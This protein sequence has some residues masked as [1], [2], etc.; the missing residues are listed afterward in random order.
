LAHA[1]VPFNNAINPA[2]I[3]ANFTKK[4]RLSMSPFPLLVIRFCCLAFRRPAS[5]CVFPSA[6]RRSFQCFVD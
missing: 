3:A 2:L 1:A 6:G 5:S 4:T